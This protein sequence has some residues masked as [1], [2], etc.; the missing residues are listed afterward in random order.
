MPPSRFGRDDQPLPC[1]PGHW[2]SGS[3]LPWYVADGLDAIAADHGLENGLALLAKVTG[4]GHDDLLAA[5][6][7][8]I[9]EWRDECRRWAKLPTGAGGIPD[10]VMYGSAGIQS[11]EAGWSS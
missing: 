8:V 3:E 9:D 5:R 1:P 11:F 10:I 7:A 6:R 2:G 4:H